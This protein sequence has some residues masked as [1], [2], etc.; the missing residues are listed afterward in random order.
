MK[1]MKRKCQTRKVG[2]NKK[3][4]DRASRRKDAENCE[5][6]AR[7]RRGSFKVNLTVKLAEQTASALS[8]SSLHTLFIFSSSDTLGH[9]PSATRPRHFHSLSAAVNSQENANNSARTNNY[10]A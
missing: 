8:L 9:A 4:I 6:C 2:G 3:N 1:M 10:R 7:R 5:K